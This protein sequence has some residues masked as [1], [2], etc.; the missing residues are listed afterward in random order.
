MCMYSKYTRN[1]IF[2]KNKIVYSKLNKQNQIS[3]FFETNTFISTYLPTVEIGRVSIYK[4]LTLSIHMIYTWRVPFYKSGFLYGNSIMKSTLLRSMRAM[5]VTFYKKLFIKLVIF[6][7]HNA[8]LW[9]WVWG[10]H[11]A[12]VNMDNTHTLHTMW[13]WS[14]KSTNMTSWYMKVHFHVLGNESD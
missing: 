2:R 4:T 5:I 6:V 9:S 11:F 12:L 3:L 13:L 8:T 14:I 10:S 7:H 1:Y